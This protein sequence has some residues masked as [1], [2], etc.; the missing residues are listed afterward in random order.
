M[1]SKDR[2]N[3]LAIVAENQFNNIYHILT[4]VS[5]NIFT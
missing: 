4:T 3:A 1:K 2:E 5:L